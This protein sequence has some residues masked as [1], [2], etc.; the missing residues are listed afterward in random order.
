MAYFGTTAVS[1]LQALEGK[2]KMVAWSENWITLANL[3][4][5]CLFAWYRSRTFPMLIRRGL[6]LVNE[7]YAATTGLSMTNEEFFRCGERV[8]NVEKLFNLREGL[9]RESDYPPERFFREEMPD[10]PGKGSKLESEDYERLLD[11]YYEARGWDK[12][13]GVPTPEKLKAL[14]LP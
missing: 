5:L 12:K 3:T 4:G 8:Y 1:D 11:D 7:I 10:G 14:G 6:E 2:G 9:G 13:T